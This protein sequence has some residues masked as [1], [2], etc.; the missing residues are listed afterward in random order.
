MNKLIK[1]LNWLDQN[2]VKI[3]LAAFILIVPLYPK[4]PFININYTYIAVRLED[5]FVG[6]MV[7]IFLIQILRKKNQLNTKF[8]IPIII[9]WFAVF[10]SFVVGAFFQ[11]TI[12]YQ[13]VGFLNTVRRVEYMVVFFIAASTIKTKKD[14]WHLLILFSFALFIVNIYG[15]GQKFG[16][17]PAI[18]TMNPEYSKGRIVYLTPEARISSTFGGHYDLAIYLAFSIPLVLA[19]Y[20]QT[21]KQ[22]FLL[23]F[24]LSLVSLFYTS[25]RISFIAYITT[26]S[27]FLIFFRKFFFY[28]FL[29]SVTLNLIFIT[30]DLTKRFL[31]TF[32]VKQILVNEKTGAIYVPQNI[33]TKELPAGTFSIL[34][35]KKPVKETQ[36]IKDFRQELIKQQIAEQKPQQPVVIAPVLTITKAP[37]PTPTPDY[38]AIEQ[39]KIASEAAV[40]IASLS[41]QFKAT[42]VILSDISFST[43]LQVEWPRA[44]TAFR[45]Y[46]LFGTGPSSITE[47]TDNDYL[48][49]LGETGAFGTISFLYLILSLLVYIW[50]KTRKVLENQ[51]MIAY[52]IVFGAISLFINAIYFD[53]FEASKVAFTFWTLIGMFIGFLGLY[54]T[55]QTI[56]KSLKKVRTHPYSSKISKDKLKK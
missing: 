36:E 55:K 32:Q 30:G 2:L 51:K 42:K 5:V 45:R 53:V 26:A 16:G 24:L 39:A 8:I 19:M 25:S 9:F 41:S 48:R 29:I 37:T 3:L 18:Q 56:I 38:F 33:T 46:P 13:Q 34:T 40:L 4:K 44:I 35:D 49:W 52:S 21:N 6:I 28:L 12:V 23:L 15:L 22:P 50:F 20:F 10:I 7:A 43:R 31:K 17:F 11:K 14:L 27:L 47:A 54:D 1:S